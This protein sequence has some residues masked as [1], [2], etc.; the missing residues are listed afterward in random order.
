MKQFITFTNYYSTHGHIYLFE[1]KS[2]TTDKFKKYKVK[3]KTKLGRTIKSL[4]SDR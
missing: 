1:Y 3:V 2:K 4:N